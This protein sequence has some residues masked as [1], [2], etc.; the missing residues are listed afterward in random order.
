MD[1]FLIHAKR[2]RLF[3]LFHLRTLN[4]N[5]IHYLSMEIILTN[6][7]SELLIF[8]GY[9]ILNTEHWQ[10]T[11]VPGAAHKL[12]AMAVCVQKGIRW[13]R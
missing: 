9:L 10:T 11:P 12:V 7:N 1:S 13:D 3:K 2:D 4:R 8:E 5:E 6:K